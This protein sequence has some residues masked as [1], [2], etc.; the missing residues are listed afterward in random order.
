MSPPGTTSGFSSFAEP[1]HELLE[2]PRM[3]PVCRKVTISGAGTSISGTAQVSFGARR[4]CKAFKAGPKRHLKLKG[5]G[6]DICLLPF[7]LNIISF[8]L[9]YI[10]ITYR[11]LPMDLAPPKLLLAQLQPLPRQLQTAPGL[12]QQL[13]VAR[14]LLKAHGVFQITAQGDEIP[15]SRPFIKA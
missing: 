11:S 13:L 7:P 6:F 4:S 2:A 5:N 12:H 8:I 14:W 10:Y 9:Y 15:T 1:G 3:P